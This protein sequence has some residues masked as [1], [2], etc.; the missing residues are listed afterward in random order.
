MV[1]SFGW[2]IYP[3]ISMN[4]KKNGMME[5]FRAVKGKLTYL[6]NK[7]ISRRLA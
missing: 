6:F 5:F 1:H 3:S 7:R 2:K 4:P